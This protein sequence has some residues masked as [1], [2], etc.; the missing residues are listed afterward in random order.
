MKLGALAASLVIAFST[1]CSPSGPQAL[2]KGEAL[3]A[4]GHAQQALP[5]LKQAA[6]DLPEQAQAWNHLGLA[7]HLTGDREN[8]IQAYQRA[9][10][11]NRNLAVVHQNLGRLYQETGN[12]AASP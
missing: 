5:L 3:L 10:Q 9:L 12:V 6:A 8:A 1:G 2:L 7:Y 11:K 4:G